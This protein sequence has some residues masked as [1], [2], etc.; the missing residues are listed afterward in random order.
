MRVKPQK[1][2]KELEVLVRM[3]GPILYK[4]SETAEEFFALPADLEG[5]T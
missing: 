3:Q 5:I 2:S 4:L 1:I